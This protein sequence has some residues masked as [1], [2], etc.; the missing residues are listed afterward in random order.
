M[1][2]MKLK[3]FL[4]LYLALG[5][6]FFTGY[7]DE[8]ITCVCD[9]CQESNH[10][11]L[12]TES[13]LTILKRGELEDEGV[14]ERRCILD[15]G[16]RM[17]TCEYPEKDEKYEQYLQ[18]RC[19]YEDYC[20]ENVS[21]AFP[22]FPAATS[23]STKKGQNSEN[24]TTEQ[25]LVLIT[26]G[27][28]IFGVLVMFIVYRCKRDVEASVPSESPAGHVCGYEESSG[29]TGLP[30]MAQITVA[31]NISIIQLVGRGRFGQV[32]RAKWHEEDVAVKSFNSSQDGSWNRE[33]E[34]YQT[35]M[36]RHENILG[37][38][39]SD[40]KD[41]GSYTQ[42]WLITDYHQNGSL[43][44]YLQ[45]TTLDVPGLMRLAHSAA[46]GLAHLHRHVIGASNQGKP[47]MAHRDIKS[48]NILVK[49]DGT[50]C[51]ADLGLAVRGTSQGL[52]DVPT[53][54]RVGTSRY[55]APEFLGDFDT[56]SSL[57][58]YKRGD[59]YSFALVLWEMTRRCV[60]ERVCEEYQLPYYDKV[61]ADPS[62]EE[63][64]EVV[65]VEKY[66][67]YCPD[68][69]ERHPTLKRVSKMTKECWKDK[70]LSRL[71]CMRVS[72]SLKNYMEEAAMDQDDAI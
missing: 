51:I 41:T 30:I 1:L 59:V 35:V 14:I 61:P 69:W 43:C 25:T 33:T 44:D 19:C 45:R 68:R 3:A 71:T 10:T 15:H 5:T 67:P 65:C 9:Y 48:K 11:C 20:N 53:G 18:Y 4:T 13:C 66:R 64:Y 22:P 17:T 63:V 29:G 36:L 72:K 54:T 23:P 39:A 21:I 58:G 50:C 37:F 12:T 55:L 47:A 26:G 34:I 16:E 57:D 32:Y 70:P 40:T 38:I 8:I 60:T 28:F 42:L 62:V 2:P 6:L 31:R 49:D 56:V 46:K 52:V 24:F 27:C 7:F